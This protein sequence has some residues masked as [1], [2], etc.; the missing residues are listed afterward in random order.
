MGTLEETPQPRRYSG[1][2]ANAAPRPLGAIKNREPTMRKVTI[3]VMRAGR[4]W[5]V[6]SGGWR[7]ET[8]KP[9]DVGFDAEGIGIA[10][11]VDIS[12]RARAKAQIGKGVPVLQVVLAGEGR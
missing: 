7:L 1:K 5:I 3:N 8:G 6:G 4:Y 11:A 9:F 10:I 2:E 12:M